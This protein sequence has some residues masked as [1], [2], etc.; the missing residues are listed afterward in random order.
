MK[1]KMLKKMFDFINEHM[2][3]N[4]L[5]KPY[6]LII[7]HEQSLFAFVIDG[8]CENVKGRHFMIGITNH[9]TIKNAFDTMVH[10]MI[11]Q[12]LMETKEYGKHGKPFKKLCQK[13][14]DIFYPKML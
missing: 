10:E 9:L 11:H 6:F 12:Y 1:I 7:D 8:Y 4:F 14:V 5:D 3:D 13:G 2:F